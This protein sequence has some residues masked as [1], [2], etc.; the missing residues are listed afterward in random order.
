[1]EAIQSSFAGSRHPDA[2]SSSSASVGLWLMRVMLTVVAILRRPA[3]SGIRAAAGATGTV[4][5]RRRSS[6][7]AID[8]L[9][10]GRWV[11]EALDSELVV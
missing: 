4:G 8:V 9:L 5:R 11:E 3:L 1:M 2:S 10:R 7:I 6:I